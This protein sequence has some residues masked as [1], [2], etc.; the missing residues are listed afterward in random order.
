MYKQL[1]R[2]THQWWDLMK[3]MKQGLRHQ[4]EESTP[5]GSMAIF[6]PACT[7]PISKSS[8]YRNELVWTFV[9]YSNFSAKHMRPRSGERDVALS[10]GMVFRANPESYKAHL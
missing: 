4:P 2:A 10:A 9:M 7:A 1:L 3:R 6:C 8:S 5:D